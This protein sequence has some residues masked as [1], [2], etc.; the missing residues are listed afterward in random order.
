MPAKE[1][2]GVKY[3]N[4]TTPLFYPARAL[5]NLATPLLAMV[6]IGWLIAVQIRGRVGGKAA[7]NANESHSG[8][9]I[10]KE[11]LETG[12]NSA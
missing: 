5:S 7:I 11:N 9:P 12:G 2:E 3:S 8:C 1:F 10:K 4:W 6:K